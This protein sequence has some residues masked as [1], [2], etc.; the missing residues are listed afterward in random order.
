MHVRH[1]WHNINASF[2]RKLKN[3]SDILRAPNDF[4][5]QASQSL[6]EK[7]LRRTPCS[8]TKLY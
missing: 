1:A 2:R 7:G 8:L 5:R 3:K 6:G 4:T